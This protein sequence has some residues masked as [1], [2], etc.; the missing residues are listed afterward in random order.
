MEK[1]TVTLILPN[2]CDSSQLRGLFKEALDEDEDSIKVQDE[3]LLNYTLLMDTIWQAE[4]HG[5]LGKKA[6]ND[7]KEDRCP[8]CKKVRTVEKIELRKCTCEYFITYCYRIKAEGILK[9][10]TKSS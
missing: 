3:N 10:V 9:I 4:K 6:S 2:A 8:F 1:L 5:K 7:L